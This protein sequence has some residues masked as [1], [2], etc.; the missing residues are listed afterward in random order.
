MQHE[1]HVLNAKTLCRETKRASVITPP[2]HHTQLHKCV[3]VIEPEPSLPLFIFGFRSL[4]QSLVMDE[5][6]MTLASTLAVVHFM[7]VDEKEKKKNNKM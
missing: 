6:M 3:F 2:L 5:T 1:Q 7:P 4:H